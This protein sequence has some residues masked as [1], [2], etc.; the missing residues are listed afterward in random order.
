MLCL[1]KLSPTI[2]LCANHP[3]G[4]HIPNVD[5]ADKNQWFDWNYLCSKCGKPDSCHH[6]SI[7]NKNLCIFITGRWIGLYIFILCRWNISK[8]FS[9]RRPQYIIITWS[10]FTWMQ[11][12]KGGIRISGSKL[13]SLNSEFAVEN[14]IYAPLK[15]QNNSIHTE[16]NPFYC[17]VYPIDIL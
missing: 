16:T 2:W 13:Y 4:L 17:D 6:Q 15:W 1:I 5:T 11:N 14:Q 10:I 12:I 7:R 3:N 9:E 8:F